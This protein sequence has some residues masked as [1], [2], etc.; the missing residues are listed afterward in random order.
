MCCWVFCFLLLAFLLLFVLILVIHY[1]A[2]RLFDF[3]LKNQTQVKVF[4][5][6]IISLSRRTIYCTV[7]QSQMSV[8]CNELKLGLKIVNFILKSKA[9]IILAIYQSCTGLR[10]S[11]ECAENSIQAWAVRTGKGQLSFSFCKASNF[12]SLVSLK[13]AGG[14]CSR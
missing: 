9:R 4:L 11:A 7:A 2:K 14:G 13:I 8:L 5:S 12:S 10:S 3:G 1:K 6:L